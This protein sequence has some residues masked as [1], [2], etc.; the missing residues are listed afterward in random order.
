M[1][2][3]QKTIQKAI[4]EKGLDKLYLDTIDECTD[5]YNGECYFD[6]KH[7]KFYIT[8]LGNQEYLQNDNLIY[9]F[10]LP[11]GT[12]NILKP[13][14]GNPE[15]VE[16]YREEF[17]E[18]SAQEE[19]E[20]EYEWVCRIAEENHEEYEKINNEAT[21]NIKDA[22]EPDVQYIKDQIYNQFQSWNLY[23]EE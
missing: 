5:F 20:T 3:L 8:G 4:D 13:D 9:L 2:N 21:K 22:Y 6:K 23:G 7:N 11:A 15:E 19:R 16:N 14:W 17:E 1:K 12:Q 10:K 18:I